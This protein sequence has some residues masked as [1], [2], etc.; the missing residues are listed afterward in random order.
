MSAPLPISDAIARERHTTLASMPTGIVLAKVDH[1]CTRDREGTRI[2]SCF[3]LYDWASYD[4][5][6]EEVTK[7]IQRH[8]SDDWLG[9]REACQAGEFKIVY[10]NL[11]RAYIALLPG[12]NPDNGSYDVPFA[13]LR[14]EGIG[15]NDPSIL[16]ETLF[17]EKTG[18]VWI[19]R[20]PMTSVSHPEASKLP[21]S[22]SSIDPQRKRDL[23][24]RSSDPRPGPN[25]RIIRSVAASQ[26]QQSSRSTRGAHAVNGGPSRYATFTTI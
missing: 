26:W 17:E 10:Y 18:V 12:Q 21:A 7:L 1:S 2:W 13:V 24:R 20:V 15:E 6:K 9:F 8:C 14:H 22:H 19:T 25:E 3:F 11:L 5:F 23:G 4:T 16:E